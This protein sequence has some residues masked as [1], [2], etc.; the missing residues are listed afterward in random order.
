MSSS[1]PFFDSKYITGKFHEQ[2]TEL[3]AFGLHQSNVHVPKTALLYSTQLDMLFPT[4]SISTLPPWPPAIGITTI[5]VPRLQAIVSLHSSIAIAAPAPVVWSTILNTTAYAEWSSFQPSLTIL[6]QPKGF[7]RDHD[8]LNL[9][10]EFKATTD[11]AGTNIE[12]TQVVSDVSTPDHPS[13]Y[14]SLRLLKYDGT[15]FPNLQHVYR[16]AWVT[17]EAGMSDRQFKSERFS[18]VIDLGDKRSVYRTWEAE[19]GERAELVKRTILQGLEEG[20]ETMGSELK[21]RAEGVVRGGT[22][23][24]GNSGDVIEGADGFTGP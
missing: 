20:F 1:C 4:S 16:I 5:H 19:S 3:N 21:A 11:V 10:T 8:L 23:R 22:Q 2:S 9:G 7:E 14:V 13:N 17:R 18:E 12:R 24:G 6:S 15:F